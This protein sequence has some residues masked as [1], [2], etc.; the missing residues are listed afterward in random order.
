MLTVNEEHRLREENIKL[1]QMTEDEKRD[2][3]KLHE[4]ITIIAT[5]VG[6]DVDKITQDYLAGRR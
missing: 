6:L 2:Q 1:R 4:L 3:E 5:K